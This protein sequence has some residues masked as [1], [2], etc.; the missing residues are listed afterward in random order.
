MEP[1]GGVESSEDKIRSYIDIGPS[2]LLE[3]PQKVKSYEEPTKK[4]I[5]IVDPNIRNCMNCEGRF[6]L[7]TM[8]LCGK[9]CANCFKIHESVSRTV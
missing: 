7:R 9:L 4:F 5:Q 8:R 1:S 3:L 2:K 6:R